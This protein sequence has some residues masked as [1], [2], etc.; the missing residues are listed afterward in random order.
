[1]K[2]NAPDPNA[3]DKAKP[4]DKERDVEAADDPPPGPVGNGTGGSHGPT[5]SS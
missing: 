4:R 3:T 1:M 2:N 5:G